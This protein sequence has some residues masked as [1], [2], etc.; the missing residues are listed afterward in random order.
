MNAGIIQRLYSL[1]YVSMSANKLKLETRPLRIMMISNIPGKEDPVELSG[2]MLYHPTLKNIKGLGKTPILCTNYSYPSAALNRFRYDQRVKFFFRKDYFTKKMERWYFTTKQLTAEDAIA[3]KVHNDTTSAEEWNE[4]VYKNAMIMLKLLFP[5]VYPMVENVFDSY[6]HYFS[7]DKSKAFNPFSFKAILPSF[8]GNMYPT[9]APNFSYLNIGGTKYTITRAVWLNDILNHPKYKSLLLEF[10]IF[11]D[12]MASKQDE[13]NDVIEL[14][15]RKINKLPSISLDNFKDLQ[16]ETDAQLKDAL[17]TSKTTLQ[18][19]SNTLKKIVGYIQ[20]INQY[21]MSNGTPGSKIES[22]PDFINKINDLSAD[23][24]KLAGSPFNVN[25][26][27]KDRK[28]IK[29]ITDTAK[30]ME[31]YQTLKTVFFS[32]IIN[33]NF[34]EQD[35]E[36]VSV[37]KEKYNEYVLFVNKIKDFISPKRETMNMYLYQLIYNYAQ[38]ENQWLE[39]YVDALNSLPTNYQSAWKGLNDDV[40]RHP[41]VKKDDVPELQSIMNTNLDFIQSENLYEVYL[42]VSVIGGEL[43]SKNISAINCLYKSEHLDEMYQK[44]KY[45]NTYKPWQV[46]TEAF[47][48]LS[49]PLKEEAVKEAKS[50]AASKEKNPGQQ[51]DKEEPVDEDEEPQKG[52]RRRRRS[53]RLM[54]RSRSSNRITRKKKVLH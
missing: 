17:G 32:N 35:A 20:Y 5:T 50:L 8:L 28:A 31:R 52:G 40:K 24:K 54:L 47:F 19:K 49:K 53:V 30:V 29:I 25:I 16:K 1:H 27:E 36:V 38:N 12:W 3:K 44:L 23:T 26:P 13:I 10:S 48:D 46:T 37:L 51:N 41:N 15:A 2:D 43:N 9:L 4:K 22:V 11:K 21:T 7:L 39:A 42:N 14:N 33:L 45:K 6:H 18:D 34:E